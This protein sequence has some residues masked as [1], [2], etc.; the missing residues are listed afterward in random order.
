MQSWRSRFLFWI[1]ILKVKTIFLHYI[2]HLHFF[3]EREKE[4]LRKPRFKKKKSSGAN[5][6]SIYWIS[7]FTHKSHKSWD[8][9]RV[10]SKQLQGKS[11]LSC[12]RSPPVSMWKQF[13]REKW[14]DFCIPR[15]FLKSKKEDGILAFFYIFF[16]VKPRKGSFQNIRLLWTQ[17]SKT[18]LCCF[19]LILRK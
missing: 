13:Q 9:G 18:T 8:R 19:N 7:E 2:W 17:D 1:K 11:T 15:H 12:E 14:F 3:F 6:I 10:T 16:V 4:N 5:H